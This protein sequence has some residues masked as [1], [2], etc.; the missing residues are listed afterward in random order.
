MLFRKGK[1]ISAVP[2][3]PYKKRFNKDIVNSVLR[4]NVKDDE[5]FMIGRMLKLY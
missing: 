1:L 4:S 2:P 3:I 5:N